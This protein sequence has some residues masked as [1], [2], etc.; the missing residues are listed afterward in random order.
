MVNSKKQLFFSPFLFLAHKLI[1]GLERGGGFYFKS[2][3][4]K[5]LKLDKK[6][7]NVTIKLVRRVGIFKS[8]IFS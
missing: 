2:I 8:A 5:I 6:Q 7:K 1:C 3:Q 4:G